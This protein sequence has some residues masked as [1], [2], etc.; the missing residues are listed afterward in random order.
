MYKGVIDSLHNKA[1]QANARIGKMVILPFPFSGSPQALQQSFMDAMAILQKYGKPDLFITM[2]CN[3]K[4][5]EIVENLK[6]SQTATDRPDLI[7]RVFHQEVKELK[8]ELIVK[9]VF[10]KCSAYVYVVEFQKR[11]LPHVHTL[12]WL[13]EDSKIYDANDVDEIVSAEIPDK[14]R[15]PLLYD[16]V[17]QCMIHGPCGQQNVNSP[18]VDIKTNRCI[19]RFLKDY[20]SETNYHS[21]GYPVY[22]RRDDGNVIVFDVKK[23]GTRRTANN[24]DVV[25]YNAY[26]LLKFNSHI[27]V[28]ICST[29]QCIKYLFKYCYKG[30]DCAIIELQNG[31]GDNNVIYNEV[32]E[33]ISTRYV[34]PPEAM[35]RLYEY[36][37]DEQSHAIYR[38]A[39]HVEDEQIVYFEEGHEKVAVDKNKESTLLAWFTLNTTDVE[40]QWVKRKKF[41]KPVLSRMY[42]VSPKEAERYYLRVWL[43]HGRGAQLF[44]DVRTCDGTIYPTYL[45]AAAARKLV[46][47]DEEWDKCLAEASTLKFPTEM[48]RLFAYI[49]VFGMPI[50]AR[51]LF[52]KYKREFVDRNVYNKQ[53]E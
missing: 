13:D 21:K 5:K 38:L 4:W 53:S 24:R 15:Y 3:P 51:Q 11:G 44:Q 48:C 1:G 16:I 2:T 34:C 39:V 47:D 14:T 31:Q 29:V 52:E 37:M 25:P 23:D 35:H 46:A 22:R 40:A 17:K 19:K 43:L 33:Y 41:V 42:F 9:V 49:C 36:P 27:N 26:L 10:G 45:E 50:N 28:K 8:A 7:A 18:C 32:D 6:P 20:V 12:F 30:H